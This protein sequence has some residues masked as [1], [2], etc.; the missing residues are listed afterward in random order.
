MKNQKS[1]FGTY[2][3]E[4]IELFQLENDNGMIVKIMNYGATI[5][6]ISIP[7]DDKSKRTELA[8]G[9][10]NFEAYFAKE[11]QE[12][13]P[14]FGCTVGRYCSQIKDA[15]FA[16]DGKEYQ[17][18]KN[19]GENNLHGGTVGFDKKV[20]QAESI[21][22]TDAV[23]VQLKLKSA[24]MEEGFPGNVVATVRFTLTNKNEIRI[25]YSATTDKTTPLSLTNHTYFNLSGFKSDITKHKVSVLTGKRLETD[26]TGAATGLIL[27]LDEAADDLRK[28]EIVADVHKAME[29]GFEHFFVFEDE[30]FELQKVAEVVDP[31]SGRKLEV[32]TTEPCM[33]FYTGMY[34]SDE[35]KRENGDQFGKYRGFCCETH[36]YQNGPNIVGSPKTLTKAGELFE[37]QTVFRL[38]F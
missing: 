2:Q 27:D 9:F 25:N 12:N 24:D 37:S 26:E 7:S 8:C 20:W 4:Q 22:T 3:G 28:G 21:N 35:L 36:R 15:K 38:A 31:E 10:D 1:H 6:S 5:T 11:Y 30:K 14:Y 33:L 18:A 32:E 16:I 23:A 34:T 29:T 17:L 13:S 19:C